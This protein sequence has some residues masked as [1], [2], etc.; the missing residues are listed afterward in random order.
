MYQFPVEVSIGFML[1]INNV[2]EIVETEGGEEQ[3]KLITADYLGL[4][5]EWELV[6]M[7]SPVYLRDEQ[8]THEQE[9]YFYPSLIPGE[10]CLM[11]S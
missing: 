5:D 1:E 11:M 9:L 6:E 3:T 7:V 2:A 4:H 8:V 10:P